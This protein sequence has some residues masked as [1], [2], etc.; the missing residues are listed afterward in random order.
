M[1]CGAVWLLAAATIT[2]EWRAFDTARIGVAA[3]GAWLYLAFAGSLAAYS[4]YV[5]LL[6]KCPPAQA[7]THAYVNPAIAVLVGWRFGGEV[8]TTMTLLAGALLLGGVAI[9][10]SVRG[11]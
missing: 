6:R 4:A 9:I 3:M 1:L 5:Y 7:S 11:R 8:V 10:I 2:G